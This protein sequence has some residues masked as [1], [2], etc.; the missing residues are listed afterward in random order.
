MC[1]VTCGDVVC[2]VRG[3]DIPVL[4]DGDIPSQ[5]LAQFY[6]DP[7]C[8]QTTTPAAMG[9]ARAVRIL[10][11]DSTRLYESM[12]MS[13]THI[14]EWQFTAYL[15]F[16]HMVQ[17][18]ILLTDYNCEQAFRQEARNRHNAF[19]SPLKPR[20]AA[21]L[22]PNT[23]SSIIHGSIRPPSPGPTPKTNLSSASSTKIQPSKSSHWFICPCCAVANDH[24]SPACPSQVKGPK[25]VPQYIKDTTMSA[26]KSAPISES[27]R[28]NL[29]RMA[30]ATYAKLDKQ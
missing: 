26:I 17:T 19:G 10:V 28:A 29:L 6:I 25:K 4:T 27:A 15:R 16:T 3:Y 24:F 14:Q 7:K 30:T 2:D 20:R 5:T 12:L 8:V 11:R 23:H 18:R 13:G 22:R 1:S 21:I 9:A